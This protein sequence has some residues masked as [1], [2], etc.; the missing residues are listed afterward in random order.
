MKQEVVG[1]TS[2]M[3]EKKEDKNGERKAGESSV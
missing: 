2:A 3:T 1:A